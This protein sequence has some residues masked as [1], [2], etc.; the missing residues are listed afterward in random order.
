MTNKQRHKEL[1][2]VPPLPVAGIIGK[3]TI[4]MDASKLS[5]ADEEKIEEADEEAAIAEE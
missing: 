4:N 5:K 1:I 3:V 2:T